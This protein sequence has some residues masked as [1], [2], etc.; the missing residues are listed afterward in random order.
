MAAYTIDYGAGDFAL[1]SLTQSWS[2]P[3][4]LCLLEGKWFIGRMDSR[5]VCAIL[6]VRHQLYQDARIIAR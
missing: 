5:D 3:R 6:V 4:V 1:F 2:R